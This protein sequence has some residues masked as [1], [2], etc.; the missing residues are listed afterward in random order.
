MKQLRM[1]Q[2]HDVHLVER[3]E[4]EEY[5]NSLHSLEEYCID[6]FYSFVDNFST[7]VWIS[8]YYRCALLV[9][10]ARDL[11]E[12]SRTIRK[13]NFKEFQIHALQ[14]VISS[15]SIYRP[16]TNHGLEACWVYQN[17]K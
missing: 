2:K 5:L 16:H 15:K 17:S 6:N 7:R 3:Q 14:K 12:T 10:L 1:N 9:I 4:R 11:P 13:T 8:S